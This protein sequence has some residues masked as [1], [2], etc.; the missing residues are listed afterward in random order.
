MDGRPLRST[1]HS[2][3]NCLWWSAFTALT[4]AVSGFHA[5]LLTRFCFGAGEAGAFPSAGASIASWF[6]TSE[7]GRAFGSFLYLAMQAGGALSPLLVVPIQMRYGWRASFYVFALLGVVW[8][9][10]WFLWFRNT[11]REK[12]GVTP[13]ELDEI[14]AAA[15]RREH[16]FPWGV[17]VRSKNFWAILFM[18]LTL[19]YGSYFFI[20]W[21]HTYLVRARNFSERD[22]LLSTLPF[23][24]GAC[25]NVGSG[26]TSDFLLKRFG[27]K[28]ARCRVGIIGLASGG[29]FAL[30]AAFT[31][32]KVATLLLLCFSFAGI[33]FNQSMTFPIC[34][35]VARKFPG[36]MGGAMNMAGQVGSFLSGIVFGY[37]AKVSG[38]YDRPLILM[39]LVLGFGALIWLKIDPTQQLVAEGQ[40][41]LAK[42]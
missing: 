10:V 7:R 34:I 5:L 1:A 17:A 37:V 33:C 41:E 4:G 23:V 18:G 25:A 15:G 38:S 14:G 26:V 24:F 11:P 29:L 21:L 42:A 3:P 36:S 9:V 30:L 35:D 16:R 40:P 13:S 19:G 12:R 39:A 31:P 32:S 2:D 6:P 8:A 22:L 27:L 20:A 28:A